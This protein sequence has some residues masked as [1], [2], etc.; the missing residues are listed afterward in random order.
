MAVT[1]GLDIGGN[2]VRAAVVDTSKSSRVVRR[3]AE[4]PLPP[5]AVSGGE[6]VE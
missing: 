3:Y 5:G 6:I 1:V 2:A 4:M